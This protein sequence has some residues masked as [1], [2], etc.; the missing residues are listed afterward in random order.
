MLNV[1]AALLNIVGGHNNHNVMISRP[2]AVSTMATL[3]NS[4]AAVA[5]LERSLEAHATLVWPS[6]QPS[7]VA[8][9]RAFHR[10]T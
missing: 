2:C 10:Q 3:P 8:L 7:R 9:Q 5:C 6:K 1:M 4:T